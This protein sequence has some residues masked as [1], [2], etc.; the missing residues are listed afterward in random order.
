M[1]FALQTNQNAKISCAP[2]IVISFYRAQVKLQT[3]LHNGWFVPK[4]ARISILG[5]VLVLFACSGMG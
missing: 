4:A 1:D 3:I 5:D 2:E